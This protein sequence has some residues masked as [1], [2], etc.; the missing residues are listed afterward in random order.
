MKKMGKKEEQ[1]QD[2]TTKSFFDAQSSIKVKCNFC[3]K[4][5]NNNIK[6]TLEPFP[7]INIPLKKYSLPFELIDL[8]CLIIK[9]KNNCYYYLNYFF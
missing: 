9:L 1:N 7:K 4:I 5:L 6:I 2:I 3:D 8:K